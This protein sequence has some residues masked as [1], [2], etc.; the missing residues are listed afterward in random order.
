MHMA[1]SNRLGWPQPQFIFTCVCG[2]A[3]VH[4]TERCLLCAQA[5]AT[6]LA[7]TEACHQRCLRAS[8]KP[9]SMLE[10]WAL[11]VRYHSARELLLN[12]DDG[13]LAHIL[14][15]ARL[16]G[17]HVGELTA[18]GDHGSRTRPSAAPALG[19]QPSIMCSPSGQ[20]CSLSAGLPD[21]Y[22]SPSIVH[23]PWSATTTANMV[24]LADMAKT[25][26]EIA[27]AAPKPSFS[28]VASPT[29][30]ANSGSDPERDPTP[31]RQTKRSSPPATNLSRL[32]QSFKTSSISTFC[33]PRRITALTA[34][35]TAPPTTPIHATRLR[36]RSR[37]CRRQ[38]GCVAGALTEPL[39]VVA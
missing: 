9:P 16:G 35:P 28:E 31:D 29:Q 39:S 1:Y 10:M 33:A 20:P 30:A 34:L 6:A 36:T 19:S 13:A 22:A 37:P 25:V 7:Y 14:I 24:R 2:A 23:D 21:M 12:T 32:S 3:A 8:N 11:R 4:N 15:C 26:R 27:A 38:K 5:C 18:S 17:D